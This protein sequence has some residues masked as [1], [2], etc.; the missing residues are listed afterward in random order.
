MGKRVNLADLAAEDFD[1]EPPPPHPRSQSDTQS[2]ETA[3]PPGDDH[4]LMHP[5]V[6]E[7]ALNPLNE[8]DLDAD[9]DIA[10]L[11]LTIQSGTKL[12]QPIVVCTRAAFL[13]E[14]PDQADAI[15]AARWVVLIGNRRL[16]ACRR[17]GESTIAALRND[18]LAATMYL[19]ML[20]ENGQHRQLAPLR[21][22][23]AM[24]HAMDRDGLSSRQLASRIGC[25]HTYVIQRLALLKLIPE[26]RHVFEAGGIRVELARQLGQLTP[27]VQRAVFTQGP[28]YS[29][30]G[31]ARP[32]S[33]R[34]T[35]KASTPVVAAQSLRERFS[36]EELAELIRLLTMPA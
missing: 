10:G 31:S 30:P 29:L 27:A 23:Q 17:A 5:P 19:A 11:V 24:R 13:T 25:T 36:Q 34:R 14:Y 12:I 33:A 32:V 3:F 16:V 1:D 28:P 18:D 7:V 15:G 9:E 20:I 2:V 22:A 6:G 21:E 26:F 8:R 35:V 4:A